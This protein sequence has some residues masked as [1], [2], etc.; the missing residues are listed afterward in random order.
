LST[1]TTWLFRR[2]LL[3]ILSVLGLLSSSVLAQAPYQL[4]DIDADGKPTVFDLT[5]LIALYKGEIEL[6]DSL[7]P[8]SDLNQDGKTDLTDIYLLRDAVLKRIDL[9]VPDITPD[10]DSESGSTASSFYRI[11]GSTWPGS[12]VLIEGGKSPAILSPDA[13]GNFEIDIELNKNAINK[14]F[15]TAINS[16]GDASH[17]QSLDVTHDS[18][19]PN[20]FIDFP[21]NNEELITATADIAGRIGDVLSGYQGLDVKV[22]GEQAQVI[23]G[24]GQNG[25][26]EKGGIPLQ[27]GKNVISVTAQDMLGNSVTKTKTL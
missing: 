13:N 24:I 14:I 16:N 21:A 6:N 8:F 11:S 23:V 19:P 26:F 7:K 1:Y 20:L 12:Q 3:I 10:L 27:V 4:G 5:Q 25:T 22:N 17:P 2:P 15:V 18:V 9:P